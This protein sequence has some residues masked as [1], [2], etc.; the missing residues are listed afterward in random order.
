MILW[1]VFA[2]MTVVAIGAVLWPLS[3][4]GAGGGGSD[5]EV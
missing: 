2:L 5:V 4:G 1:F 3:W